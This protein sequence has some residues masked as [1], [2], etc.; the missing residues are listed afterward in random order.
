MSQQAARQSSADLIVGCAWRPSTFSAVQVVRK[1]ASVHETAYRSIWGKLRQ[2]EVVRH[3]P[4]PG[5]RHGYRR[6]RED[7]EHGGCCLLVAPC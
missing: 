1:S 3:R 2:L 6:G 7:E 5:L 4:D